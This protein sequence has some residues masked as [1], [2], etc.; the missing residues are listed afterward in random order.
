MKGSSNQEREQQQRTK[1]NFYE[2]IAESQQA[3]MKIKL[4]D[5]FRS[6]CSL[7]VLKRPVV[8]YSFLSAA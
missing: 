7:S 8:I 3:E 5:H 6:R 1:T 2:K 4:K